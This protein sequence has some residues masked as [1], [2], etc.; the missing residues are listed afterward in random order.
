EKISLLNSNAYKGAFLCLVT[1]S[2]LPYCFALFLPHFVLDVGDQ[3][4]SNKQ[5]FLMLVKLHD[6]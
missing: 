5:C 3:N 2:H 1:Y 6:D 4:G